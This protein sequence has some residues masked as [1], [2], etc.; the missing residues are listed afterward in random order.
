VVVVIPSNPAPV[1]SNPYPVASN[2]APAASY[3][4]PIASNLVP[5]ASNPNA[6][7]ISHIYLFLFFMQHRNIYGFEK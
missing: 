7:V 2:P 3:P 1:V 4:A 6:T 5:L